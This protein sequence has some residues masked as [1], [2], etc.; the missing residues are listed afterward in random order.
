MNPYKG[1][2]V[3][4]IYYQKIKRGLL[5]A[6]MSTVFISECMC[7]IVISGMPFIFGLIAGG[8]RYCLLQFHFAILK[9]ELWFFRYS[10][11]VSKS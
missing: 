1:C 11:A 4:A 9:I 7:K 6:Q 5:T 2:N 8:L 10:I 3:S